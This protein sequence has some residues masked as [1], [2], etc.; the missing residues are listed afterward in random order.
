[1][2]LSYSGNKAI[3]AQSGRSE[4]SRFL[5]LSLTGKE[6]HIFNFSRLEKLSGNV[7]KGF[8]EIQYF[9]FS[10]KKII[11]VRKSA[12]PPFGPP[13]APAGALLPSQSREFRSLPS[14][15]HV[16]R[17]EVVVK[18]DMVWTLWRREEDPRKL[19]YHRDRGE[20][21]EITEAARNHSLRGSLHRVEVCEE[22]VELLLG[23]GTADGRHHVASAKDGLADESL[24]GGES[25]G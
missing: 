4:G 2:N 5:D 23:E 12:Y 17:G 15:L 8:C 19:P 24:V 14:R 9:I 13:F 20:G 21:I 1:M 6:R 25:A 7:F 3:L 22:I 10:I 11:S 18:G 16:R